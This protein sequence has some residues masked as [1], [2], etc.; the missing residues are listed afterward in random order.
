ML[1]FFS[2]S[3]SQNINIS[4]NSVWQ[5]VE[6]FHLSH[7]ILSILFMSSIAWGSTDNALI[8]IKKGIK[9]LIFNK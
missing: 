9:L 4:I 8:I 5:G 1:I 3:A 6:D 2:F 7:S